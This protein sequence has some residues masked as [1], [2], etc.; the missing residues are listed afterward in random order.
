[1]WN[2]TDPSSPVAYDF[3]GLDLDR[4]SFY[5]RVF[6]SS[7]SLVDGRWSWYL[8]DRTTIAAGEASA[9]KEAVEAAERVYAV[10]SRFHKPGI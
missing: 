7:L 5:A 8:S 3:T 4:S 9:L 2:K 1:V 6:L 10:W